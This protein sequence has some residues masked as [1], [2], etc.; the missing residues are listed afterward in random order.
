[1]ELKPEFVKNKHIL[2]QKYKFESICMEIPT[3]K[4]QLWNK[5]LK[6]ISGDKFFCAVHL[7]SEILPIEDSYGK[8]INNYRYTTL[9][10][11]MLL[12]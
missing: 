11:Y 7:Y 12:Q 10:Q 6:V 5:R 9:L 8:S 3:I 2:C 1:M 4:G